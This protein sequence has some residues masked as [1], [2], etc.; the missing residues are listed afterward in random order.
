MV[1]GS[2]FYTEYGEIG[3]EIEDDE[4]KNDFVMETFDEIRE[5]LVKLFPRQNGNLMDM[6]ITHSL[7]SLFDLTESI[8][9]KIK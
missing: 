1:Y 7:E 6:N 5:R 8:D 9:A 3:M 4:R 2:T